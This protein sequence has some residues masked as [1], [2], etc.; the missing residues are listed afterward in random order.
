MGYKSV[1]G[2]RRTY[3]LLE[4]ADHEY[5]SLRYYP[6]LPPYF[7]E[8]FIVALVGFLEPRALFY[9]LLSPALQRPV[10]GNEMKMEGNSERGDS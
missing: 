5:N 3:S 2:K 4:C 9:G 8:T 1:C 6:L 7:P 10:P